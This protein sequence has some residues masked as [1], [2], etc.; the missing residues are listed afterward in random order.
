MM[1][2]TNTGRTVLI[3]LPTLALCA[4]VAARSPGAMGEREGAA[5]NTSQHAENE[6]SEIIW[7]VK[8]D[9]KVVALTFD[10]GPDPR[11][12]SS[13]LRLA[14]KRGLKLTFFLVGREIQLHPAL[15]AEEVAEGHAIGNHTWDHPVMAGETAV[16][17]LL[18]IERCEDEIERICGE[19]THLFRP[20]KGLWDRDT[21]LTA[22]ALGYRMILWSVA[23]EHHS[24]HTPEEMAQR[25]LDKV[26]PGMI[27]LAHDGEPCHPA[28]REKTMRA[29]PI[30]VDGLQHQGYRFVTV[31]QLLELR[32]GAR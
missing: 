3:C 16:Q 2:R 17:D 15:A 10:D 5:A 8:S 6:P 30:L 18:E 4:M 22:E 12:T 31:P 29:L 27:V 14:R 7:R 32:A 11:Y 21:F 25:V 19:C 28:N 24:A 13:V 1:I 20:P 9:E 26:R 23:L